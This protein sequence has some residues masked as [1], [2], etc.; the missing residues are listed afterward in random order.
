M[1]LTKGKVDQG[2][3]NTSMIKHAESCMYHPNMF[4]PS[5]HS[6]SARKA[7]VYL[8]CVDRTSHQM[9]TSN[10]QH[11]PSRHRHLKNAHKDPCLQTLSLCR[12]TA[13]TRPISV[14]LPIIRC[15]VSSQ[16]A[17]AVRARLR[18]ARTNLTR[19]CEGAVPL[20]HNEIAVSLV[21]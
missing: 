16:R 14:D 19:R 17:D 13:F 4:H 1:Q 3:I 10:D 9:L 6:C 2:V 12:F 7:I 5:F 21:N 8:F 20:R 15:N 11:D 18:L